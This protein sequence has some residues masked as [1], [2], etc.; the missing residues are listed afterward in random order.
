M[1]LEMKDEEF[2]KDLCHHLVSLACIH[3]PTSQTDK[4]GP[5]KFFTSGFVMEVSGLWFFVTAGHVFQRIEKLM[6][7]HPTRR[8]RFMMVDCFGLTAKFPDP[9]IIDYANTPNHYFD[10]EDGGYDFAIMP[11]NSNAVRL[12]KANDI[13]PLI[14]GNWAHQDGV[15]FFHYCMIGFPQQKMVLDIPTHAE[16]APRYISLE[17]LT[18]A[19]ARF[20][21]H[22]V[23]MFYAR[24]PNPPAGLDIAGM[25][26]CPILGFTLDKAGN[27]SYFFVAIQSGWLPDSKI[28]YACQMPFLGSLVRAAIDKHYADLEQV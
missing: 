18:N 11:L 2:V 23:P 9:F 5:K 14:E 20:S 13:V 27:P 25:S 15:D 8:Y 21:R 19:P 28:I 10:D 7:D 6:A 17:R 1:S 22:T 12:L 16:I 26:G 4:L 24:I 3:E